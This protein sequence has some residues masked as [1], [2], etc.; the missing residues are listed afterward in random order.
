MVRSRP[1]SRNKFV[2]NAPREGQV[3]NRSMQMAQLPA[4]APEFNPTEA[5][6]VRRH[7]LPAGDNGADRLNRRS[8][9]QDLA[10]IVG[11]RMPSRDR[12]SLAFH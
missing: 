3:G 2:A 11:V 9:G 1:S 10:N 7:T 6:A 5:V 12:V 4:T 8:R